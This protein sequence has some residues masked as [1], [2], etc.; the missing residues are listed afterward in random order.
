MKSRNPST[1]ASRS[2]PSFCFGFI[3]LT[4]NSDKSWSFPARA[5]LA[6]LS[7]LLNRLPQKDFSISIYTMV[8]NKKYFHHTLLTY[9]I[10]IF[11]S[12]NIIHHI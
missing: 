3:A 5:K 12:I 2:L 7:R 6:K 1:T 8:I 9:K 10:D 11:K 4:S